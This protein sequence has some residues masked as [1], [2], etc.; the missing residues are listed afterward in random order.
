VIKAFSET[1]ICVSPELL[2]EYRDVPSLLLSHRKLGADQFNALIAGIA[3]VV[4]A[5]R[6]V[7]PKQRIMVCRDP[8]DDMVLEC[9]LAAGAD[10]LVTGDRDL[11]SIKNLPFGLK[12][13]TPKGY[14]DLPS[15]PGN[16]GR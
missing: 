8:E 11:L 4:A 10:Y 9:C 1:D 15:V 7:Y 12:I 14:L 3:A 16:K 2:Q 5:A 6:M 13:L